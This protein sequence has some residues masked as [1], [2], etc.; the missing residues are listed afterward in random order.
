VKV[1]V[2]VEE[3]GEADLALLVNLGLQPERF[4]DAV[5]VLRR[6]RYIVDA[7]QRLHKVQVVIP[8]KL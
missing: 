1:R 5:S 8:L 6:S 2:R 4:V 7:L 3:A